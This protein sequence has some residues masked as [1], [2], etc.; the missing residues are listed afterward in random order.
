MSATVAWRRVRPAAFFAAAFVSVLTLF[1]TVSG[2][3]EVTPDIED[4]SDQLDVP[5]VP[6]GNKV[7][8]VMLRLAKPTPKDFVIDLGSGDGRIVI[9][10]AKTYGAQGYGVDLNAGLVR[11]ANARAAREGVGNRAKF[12][13]RDLFKE[14]FSRATIVT[15]YLLPEV[16][17][18]LRPKLLALRPG[19]RIVS[20]DYHLGD[21]R[22][23][24]ARVVGGATGGD[25]D[26]VYYW[27][28]PARVAGRWNWTGA[29]P[30]YFN[31][32]AKYTGTIS[33]HFQDIDG[34]VTVNQVDMR[35]H[36]AK[37]TGDR[38]AFSAT[39]EMEDRVVRHDF[40]G[41]VKGDRIEGTVRL[42]G[43]VQET[44]LPWSATRAKADN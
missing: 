14:D 23:D 9:A 7:V 1:A 42:S 31:G 22:F 25:E 33:Q 13:V 41:I 17:L 24:D 5:F 6:S 36:D 40:T 20:H 12:Y 21:W 15:M 10:A 37:L 26:V 11:I 27:V 19:T 43:G 32:Q 35:I 39:G 4:R 34:K 18:H 2:A 30:T 38:I 29:Y 3:Q 8:D 16:V 28:V 44:T